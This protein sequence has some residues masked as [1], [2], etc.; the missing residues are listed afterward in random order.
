LKRKFDEK[1]TVFESIQ[2]AQDQIAGNFNAPEEKFKKSVRMIKGFIEEIQNF[3][4]KLERRVFQLEHY[5]FSPLQ[6]CIMERIL[7]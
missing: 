7:K 1:Q 3:V 4:N 2:S 6:G 5:V